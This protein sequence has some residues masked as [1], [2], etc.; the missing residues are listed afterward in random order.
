MYNNTYSR[1]SSLQ[2][3]TMSPEEIR[4]SSVTEITKYQSFKSDGK[5]IPQGLFD[6]K[7][8]PTDKSERCETDLLPIDLT[9][10]YFGR[11][12]LTVPIFNHSYIDT[13]SEILSL[14]CIDCGNILKPPFDSEKSHNISTEKLIYYSTNLIPSEKDLLSL[15][16]KLRLARL[17]KIEWEKD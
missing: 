9:P 15:P 4:D 3:G 16:K 17:K 8:S 13:I 6:A 7:M 5:P 2:F 14:I 12:E 1:I 10:G 11:I